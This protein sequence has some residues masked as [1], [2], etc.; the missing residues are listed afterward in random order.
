MLHSLYFLFSRAKK[1]VV[2]SDNNS[3]LHDMKPSVY[4]DDNGNFNYA[5]FG[6]D[7]MYWSGI[8]TSNCGLL[9]R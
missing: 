4:F 2:D 8:I 9:W 1:F 3:Y 6:A 7:S 5:K